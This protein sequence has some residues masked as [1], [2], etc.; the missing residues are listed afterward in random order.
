M[1]TLLLPGMDGTG[2]LFAR[3]RPLLDPALGARVVSFPP[4]RPLGYEQLLAELDIPSGPLA[5]VAESFSGPLGILL[6]S[7][8]ADRVRGLVLVATFVRAPSKL[9]ARLGA[10]LGASLFRVRVPDLALRWALL[11]MD[12]EDAE[13][14]DVRAAIESVDETVLALRL[15]EVT[16]V[17][18]TREFASTS[19]PT[20]Y[21][22]GGR[23]R[24]V[25]VKVLDQLRVLRPDMQS[26]VLDAPHLVLQRAPVE[27]AR[28]IHEF[29]LPLVA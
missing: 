20:L 29:L 9:A 13:V 28:L 18:V 19:V 22:G 23:D 8:Y 2:G 27:A 21:L 10:S 5:I 1:V 6:A 3:L 11:G 15:R 24:L 14:S 16:T 26:R 25:G 4:D 12:A 17:D 7:R